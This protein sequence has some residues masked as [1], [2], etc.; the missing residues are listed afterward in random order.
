VRPLGLGAVGGERGSGGGR[1]G[2]GGVDE[3]GRGRV[4]RGISCGRG[5][6]AV[7]VHGERRV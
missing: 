3:V 2:V 6:A 4:G 5:G 7:G 1:V